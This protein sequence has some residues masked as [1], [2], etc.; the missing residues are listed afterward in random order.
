MLSAFLLAIIAVLSFACGSEGGAP[1]NRAGVDQR[2]EAVYE[3]TRDL[4]CA[5]STECSSIGIGAKPCGGPWKYLVFSAITVDQEELDAAVADLNAYEA[6][7]N[8][9]E[10]IISDCSLAPPAVP[11]C[12]SNTCVDLDTAQ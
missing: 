5:N 2:Y 9:Q 6:G 7:Y 3:L 11:G 12:V 10:G 8:R 1:Y 4:S